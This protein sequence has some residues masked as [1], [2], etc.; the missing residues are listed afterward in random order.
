MYRPC[1]HTSYLRVA[2]YGRSS[3][4]SPMYGEDDV[5]VEETPV[6]AGAVATINCETLDERRDVVWTY[7]RHPLAEPAKDAPKKH[8]IEDSSDGRGHALTILCVSPE[9]EGEYGVL[10]DAIYTPVT[11]IVVVDAEEVITQSIREDEAEFEISLRMAPQS[12]EVQGMAEVRQAG[13]AAEAK[14]PGHDSVHGIAEV[15]QVEAAAEEAVILRADITSPDTGITMDISTTPHTE[16][17]PVT[18]AQTT[19][20]T[21]LATEAPSESVDATNTE[22]ID[23]EDS[24]AL[25]AAAERVADAIVDLLFRFPA[26]EEGILAEVFEVETEAV[27][28]KKVEA[29]PKPKFVPAP[30]PDIEDFAQRFVD[31]LFEDLLENIPFPIPEE[32][33]NY[34][35]YE[36]EYGIVEAQRTEQKPQ[37]IEQQQLS[38]EQLIQEAI[39]EALPVLSAGAGP[40]GPEKSEIPE[41]QPEKSEKPEMPKIPSE[42]SIEMREPQEIPEQIIETVHQQQLEAADDFENI[43]RSELADS[44]A[45]LETVIEKRIDEEEDDE[46]TPEPEPRLPD[47]ELVFRRQPEHQ[48]EAHIL[49]TRQQLELTKRMDAVTSQENELTV[50]LRME[51]ADQT[52]AVVRQLV[53]DE[54]QEL[55]RAETLTSLTSSAVYNR[56]IFV[57]QLKE[58]YVIEEGARVVFKV[59]FRGNP[60]PDVAWYIGG[61]PVERNDQFNVVSEDGVSFLEIRDF[62]PRLVGEMVCEATSSAGRAVTTTVLNI[63]PRG[64]DSLQEPLVQPGIEAPGSSHTSIDDASLRTDTTTSSGIG[65]APYAAKPLPKTLYIQRTDPLTL[66]ATFGGQPLPEVHWERDGEQIPMDGETALYEDGIALLRLDPNSLQQNIR[67]TVYAENPSLISEQLGYGARVGRDRRKVGRSNQPPS[68]TTALSSEQPSKTTIQIVQPAEGPAVVRQK[69]ETPSEMS[70]LA[71]PPRFVTELPEQTEITDGISWLRIRRALDDDAGEYE[72]HLQNPHGSATSRCQ[73]KGR[74]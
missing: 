47:V 20:D 64:S 16:E 1:G 34:E 17:T 58:G 66:R 5:R 36:K 43:D 65:Q 63:K 18:V 51:S 52:E 11:R 33:E 67:F 41:Q 27:E 9:D 69:S 54:E 60:L 46:K 7:N 32:N 73:L 35:K 25:Q 22:K 45:I 28:A 31:K 23:E 72:V 44:D 2:R 55:S 57:V 10:I 40:D 12:D 68:R 59:L 62:S 29:K 49:A 71:Q 38:L 15:R 19:T 13:H 42:P 61:N 30:T 3:L 48:N 39:Q 14:G 24:R 50:E 70:T 4:R 53:Y 21:G 56:P 26:P 8:A 37:P 74:R 6:P